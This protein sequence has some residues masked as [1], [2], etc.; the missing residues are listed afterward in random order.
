MSGDWPAGKVILPG[1]S[2]VSVGSR[3]IVEAHGWDW[4]TRSLAPLQ[5]RELFH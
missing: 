2:G 1:A 4:F 5:F 3:S